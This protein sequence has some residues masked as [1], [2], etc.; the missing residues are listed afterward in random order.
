M[1]EMTVRA[2]TF[3][4]ILGTGNGS[5]RWKWS[6]VMT[7]NAYAVSEPELSEYTATYRVYLGDESTGSELVDAANVP[8]Y[9]SDTVTLNFTTSVPE[10]RTLSLLGA[11]CLAF[12][13]LARRR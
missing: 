10:P 8:L 11:A 9:G 5:D 2:M 3:D 12:L 7:H 4:P 13:S 6:G 1:S